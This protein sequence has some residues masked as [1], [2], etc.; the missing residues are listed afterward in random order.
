MDQINGIDVALARLLGYLEAYD[1]SGALAE[2]QSAT[3]VI[4]E[5]TTYFFMLN[6]AFL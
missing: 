6:F 4:R 3:G 1:K 2:Q 5:M